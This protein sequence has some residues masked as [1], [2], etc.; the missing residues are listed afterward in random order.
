M[1][2]PLTIDFSRVEDIR[3]HPVGIFHD[4]L[5]TPR[6]SDGKV[7][8]PK[9]IRA[10][11]RRRAA[12]LEKVVMTEQEQNILYRKP[13]EEWDLDE[14]A[15]GRPKNAQGHFKGPKPRWIS[16]IV[17]EEAMKHYQLAVKSAMRSTTVDALTLLQ[18]VIDDDNV[19]D[20]GKPLVPASVK[21]DVAKFLIEHSI[22]KPMQRIEQD[23]SVKLQGILGQ[24]MVNPAEIM[25][26]D[27]DRRM[28]YDVGHFPGVTMELAE[29]GSRDD[30][31]EFLPE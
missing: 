24:V 10:R 4:N 5:R 7:L 22:G 29:G 26:P 20:K 3:Q 21:V 9:Q 12:R 19:D 11:A 31:D 16:Q 25:G 30:D 18:E 1:V 13:V 15:R 27:G 2:N 28:G 23:I 6:D 17:H 14:L 8:T